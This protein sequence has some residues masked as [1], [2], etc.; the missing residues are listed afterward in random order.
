MGETIPESKSQPASAHGADPHASITIAPPPA[1][2]NGLAQRQTPLPSL[3]RPSD[4]RFLAALD[5]GALARSSL[6]DLSRVVAEL[7]PSLAGA[8]RANEQL[9]GE[10][11]ALRLE[12]GSVTE[13][14]VALE[15]RV[16]ELERSLSESEEAAQR[17]RQFLTDQ[18]DAFLA[19]LLEEHEEARH[20]RDGDASRSG[21]EVVALAQQVA[22]AVSEREHA[23]AALFAVES[24]L[25]RAHDALSR[26]Q[27]ARDEAHARADR[28]ERER[29]EL[30]AEAS[31]LRAR[32]GTP[33]PST[34]PPPPAV[35]PTRPPSVRLP[36]SLTLDDGELDSNLHPRV[37]TP[38]LPSVAPRYGAPLTTERT[39][40]PS[41]SP[42]A[43][44]AAFPRESTRPGVGGPK[45]LP[46]SLPPAFGP[47]PSGWTPQLPP[48][49][50]ATPPVPRLMSAANLPPG[51]PSVLPTLKQK[52]APTTRPLIDYSLGEGGVQSELLEGA[53]LS[54][55]PRK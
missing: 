33:R 22:E 39:R 50:D 24:E 4:A 12:L 8:T 19:A 2:A 26:A 49:D 18:H 54:T 38:S 29:D 42:D 55:P 27:E 43:T 30:R 25:S 11:E 52:P 5:A 31:Q 17:E 41:S 40:P 36:A 14:K 51:L 53:R 20:G 46:S 9:V 10:L 28:R 35:S 1:H 23:E 37:H 34:V 13:Q 32:L 47:P 44:A 21:S 15:H 48:A 16:D 3:A 6:S 7:S 45:P